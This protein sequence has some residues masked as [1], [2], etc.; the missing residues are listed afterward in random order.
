MFIHCL[1]FNTLIQLVCWSKLHPFFEIPPNYQL[2]HKSHPDCP[3]PQ[4]GN[5]SLPHPLALLNPEPATCC[6]KISM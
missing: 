1:I 5:L 6:T 4:R 3:L 2:L